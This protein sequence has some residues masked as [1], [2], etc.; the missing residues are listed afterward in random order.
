MRCASRTAP[1]SARAGARLSTKPQRRSATTWWRRR[2][3]ELLALAHEAI[4]ALRLFDRAR[5][6]AGA[7]IARDARSAARSLALCAEGESASGDPARARR[8]RLRV[9]MR[10]AGR[11]RAP[12]AP[13]SRASRPN[14][15][16]SRRTSRRAA[17]TRLRSKPACVSRSTRCIRSPSGASCSPATK[18]TCASISVSAAAITTRSRPAARHRNSVSSL[19]QID[20]FRALARQH[21]ARI[22]GL[23]AHLGSGI[24]DI[25]HWRS[26]YAQLASL[27]EKFSRIESLNIG[28]GLG[29]PARAGRGARSILS[30]SARRWP[31][32]RRAYPQFELW[33]EPGRYLVADA[34]VLLA[35]VTQTKRKGGVRY[36]G[37]DAGMNTLIRPA[38][39]EAWHEIVNLSRLDENDGELVQIVGPICESGDVLGSN[40]RLPRVSR[41]RRDAD[42]AGRRVRRGDGVATTTC[43]AGRR[44]GAAMSLRRSA[45]APSASA[46]SAATYADGVATLRV[47]VRRR[48]RADRAHRVSRCA[49]VSRRTVAP[50]SM[51]RSICCISSRA[52]V[53]TRPA[54]RRRSRV[55][56]RALDAE[57]AEL[58]DAL[59]LHGLG[60][61]AY[62][63]KLDLRGRIRVSRTSVVPGEGRGIGAFRDPSESHPHPR[64]S[65]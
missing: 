4:A 18:S 14:A 59:Y 16:C 58:L 11:S 54:C 62:Q 57:T 31:R 1:C 60:E 37:V 3:D 49:G 52:S 28:G 34:G 21:G 32:S 48:S 42:R 33:L 25:S 65:P 55:E 53:T 9:R 12:C 36:V 20:E 44:S 19:D 43:A 38:L 56:T 45:P 61:F 23:H 39:Y 8:G 27:A 40:R 29:V 17:S 5:A 10:L 22:V 6:H 41:R 2:R 46:S 15:S 30:R 7:R 63:N 26:V 13:P 64:P 51:R 50:R 24:L 47:R 35:R